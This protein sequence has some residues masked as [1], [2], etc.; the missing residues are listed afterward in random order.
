M[1]LASEEQVPK[2]LTYT[3]MYHFLWF[4]LFLLSAVALAGV[5]LVSG[6][7][8]GRA[9]GAPMSL[10]FFAVVAG[11][12]AFATYAVRVQ[13]LLGQLSKQDGFR[14]SA[15]SSWGVL[16]LAPVAWLGWRFIFDPLA[17]SVPAQITSMVI[18]VE[19]IVWWLSHLMSV[20]GLTRGRRKYVQGPVVG[21][22]GTGAS[23]TLPVAGEAPI[24]S[25]VGEGR[26]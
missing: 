25:L 14:W 1:P 4:I 24:P 7:P 21:Q 9:L 8:V 23:P 2:A 19:L 17:Q 16:L 6:Q 12:G 18:Q 22:P 11:I 20:R 13:L 5:F 3:L 15:T 26:K 10:V